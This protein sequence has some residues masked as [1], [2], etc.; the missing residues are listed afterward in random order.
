MWRGSEP[1]KGSASAASRLA[2][3]GHQLVFCTNHATSPEIKVKQLADFGVP[4]ADVLTSAV[5]AA[6]ACDPGERILCL[7]VDTLAGVLRAAGLNVTD[8]AELPEDGPASGFDVV[9]VGASSNWDR[10]R[11]GLAADAVRQGARFLATNTDPTYP[12]TGVNGPRLLPGAGAL[13]AA[14]SVASGR[15]P[16]VMGKPHKQTIDLILS[17]YGPV[18]YVVGDVAATDGVLSVGLNASFALVL[19]G[20]TRRED[21][22]VEPAP[23]LTGADFADIV[24]QVLG[25]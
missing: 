1:I 23:R 14:V 15:P 4:D 18:D 2:E 19:S 17:R 24:D 8:V 20:V 5:V 21:L 25:A 10:S 13:V 7:G 11:T 3:S 6:S 22:P 16:E 12:F 9:V